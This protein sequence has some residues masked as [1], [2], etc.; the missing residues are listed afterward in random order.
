LLS[1]ARRQRAH[2]LRQQC[3]RRRRQAALRSGELHH[4]QRRERPHDDPQRRTHS[5][6]ERSRRSPS[7]RDAGRLDAELRTPRCVPGDDR[8]REPVMTD[9]TNSA[10]LHALA[11]TPADA[12]A[13]DDVKLVLT[14]VFDAP[15]ELVFKAWTEPERLARWWGP[16]G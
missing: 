7:R 1:R 12:G 14:R 11:K 9:A 4:L 10:D 2:R 15:R 8:G 13:D 16:K 6:E 3:A 5:L